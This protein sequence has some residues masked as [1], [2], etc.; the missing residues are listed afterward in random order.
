MDREGVW[1]EDVLAVLAE[2]FPAERPKIFHAKL[3]LSKEVA[4]VLGEGEETAG[5]RQAQVELTVAQTCS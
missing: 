2:H 4:H 3:I 5:A 1:P